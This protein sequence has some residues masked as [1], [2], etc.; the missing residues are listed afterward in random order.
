MIHILDLKYLGIDHAI[1]A[2]L[3]ET[4]AGPVLVETGPHST[5][6]NLKAGVKTAG[7]DILDIKHVFLTHIHLDHAGA[8]WALAQHGAMVYVHPFG[9]Q[10]MADP[11]KLYNSAKRI[12]QDDMDRLWGDLKPIAREQLR[13]IDHGEKITVGDKTLTA[14]HTPGH[15]SHHIAWQMDEALFTGDVA[16]VFIEK[17]LVQPPCPPPDINLELW[18]KSIALVRSLDIRKLYL[19]HFGI[20]ENIDEHLDALRERMWEWANW[21]K[22]HWEAGKSPQEVTPAFQEF[23]N[24]QLKAAGATDAQLARFEAAN[25][26]WMS[27][28]GLMRYWKKKAEIR[29]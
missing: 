25:P 21:V 23:A 7:F 11:T 29:M 20:V 3:I 22:P 13:A 12:Y 28:A 17:V 18:E 26:A 8:A 2:F 6:E 15:A 1:A 24:A 5:F 14:W 19:T 16:G 9:E 10:H 27:V 4:N